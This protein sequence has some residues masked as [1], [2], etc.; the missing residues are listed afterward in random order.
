MGPPN[1]VLT[2]DGFDKELGDIRRRLLALETG[3]GVP[4]TQVAVLLGAVGNLA[5]HTMTLTPYT[6]VPE[7]IISF[8]L[9]QPAKVLVLCSW[10]GKIT[11]GSEF[12]F[13]Q[14]RAGTHTQVVDWGGAAQQFDS[15]NTAMQNGATSFAASLPAGTSDVALQCGVNA[16]VSALIQSSL[17]AVFLLGGG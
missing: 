17:T 4:F 15:V 2:P 7:T 12:A 3:Y 1:R 8:S 5:T 10:Y 9:G 6:D 14:L 11:A 13:F 16:G